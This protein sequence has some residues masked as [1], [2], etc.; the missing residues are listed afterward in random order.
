MENQEKAFLSQQLVCMLPPMALKVMAYLLNC[1][2]M[3]VI[4]Y[5]PKTLCDFMHITNEDLDLAIQTLVNHKLIGIKQTD[6]GYEIELHKDVINKYL[7]VK[8]Q[9]IKTYSGLEMATE[10]TWK[11]VEKKSKD[12]SDMT[13]KDLQRLLLRIEAQL[14]E[15]QQVREKVVTAEPSKEII[16]DLPW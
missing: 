13:D 14:S 11:N 8:I 6:E 10:V 1:Q 16:D 4:K 3:D 7:N 2:R 15:R 5:Y 12:L 9:T